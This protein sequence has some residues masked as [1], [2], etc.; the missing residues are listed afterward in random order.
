MSSLRNGGGKYA[1]THGR[2][3][4]LERTV[5]YPEFP[6]TPA[7]TLAA[8]AK[9]AGQYG[10]RQALRGLASAWMPSDD[11]RSRQAVEDILGPR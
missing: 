2:I 7:A 6:R 10:Y 8:P 3:S 11:A 9:M 4:T 5:K 1:E